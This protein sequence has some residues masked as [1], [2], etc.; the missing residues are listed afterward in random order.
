[1]IA[2][3]LASGRMRVTQLQR[4]LP[5][6]SAGVLDRYVQQMIA[7][8]LVTRTRFKEMPPRVELELTDAGRELLP[9]AG[10]L[11]R[12][13]ARHLWSEPGEH[14]RVD[15]DALLY[16][17]PMLLEESSGL[18][19]GSIEVIV[20]DSD[21]PIRRCY[22]VEHGH[23][24]IDGRADLRPEDAPATASVQAASDARS[25]AVH[26]D[27]DAWVAALG[28]AADYLGLRITGDQSLAER[29]LDALGWQLRQGLAQW[30]RDRS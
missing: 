29:I 26:G 27:A 24:R 14:E 17:L 4:R 7:L 16:L 3:T 22:L 18:P 15:L 1:M 5:G 11:A 9:V 25:A 2:L 8:G 28:P 21:P 6:V 13:G 23:L 30:P 10:V 12:W 20:E 19:T